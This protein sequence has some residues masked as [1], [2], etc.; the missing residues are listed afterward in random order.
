V[1]RSGAAAKDPDGDGMPDTS[2][3]QQGLYF[4]DPGDG[5]AAR[6][7]GSTNFEHDLNGDS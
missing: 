1:R 6:A 2:E 7:D 4:R 5:K 3:Q